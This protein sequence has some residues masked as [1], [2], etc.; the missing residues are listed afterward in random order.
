MTGHDG[1]AIFLR[2]LQED[3]VSC[4]WSPWSGNLPED[5]AE[6]YGLW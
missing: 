4:D 3:V 2:T 1:V 5:I 6:G